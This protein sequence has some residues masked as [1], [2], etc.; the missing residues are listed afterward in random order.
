M[1][2][3]LPDAL[4]LA[5]GYGAQGGGAADVRPLLNRRSAGVLVNSARGVLYAYEGSHS[6]YREAA[7]DAANRARDNLRSIGATL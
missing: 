5:P 7:R 1:R 6:G 2:E 3:L 4:L